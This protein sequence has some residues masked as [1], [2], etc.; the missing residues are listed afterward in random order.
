MC[1]SLPWPKCVVVSRFIVRGRRVMKLLTCL[2]IFFALA[3]ASE[4]TRYFGSKTCMQ[5]DSKLKTLDVV[6]CRSDQ[7]TMACFNYYRKNHTIYGGCWTGSKEAIAKC[8]RKGC[9]SS[10]TDDLVF[11]CCLGNECNDDRLAM[12]SSLFV[13]FAAVIIFEMKHL[14]DG[15]EQG[16]FCM[17]GDSARNSLES[18]FCPYGAKSACFAYWTAERS[19]RGCMVDNPIC[20]ME[21]ISPMEAKEKF[22]CCTS[23]NCNVVF[24]DE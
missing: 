17:Q 11:C 2:A 16:L 10:D 9:T 4:V 14:M 23:K 7:G 15:S 13:L 20:T 19:V 12:R 24:W 21:C 1:H 8:A 22:C 18:R 6:R 5:G 3:V